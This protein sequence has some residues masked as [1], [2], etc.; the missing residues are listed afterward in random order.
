MVR[1]RD[2]FSTSSFSLVKNRKQKAIGMARFDTS[3]AKIAN[4]VL[5]ALYDFLFLFFLFICDLKLK[6]KSSNQ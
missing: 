2:N 1:G 6:Q 4:P 5:C 3:S